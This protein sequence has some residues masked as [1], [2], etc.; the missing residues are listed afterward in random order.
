M[1]ATETKV[2]R[3]AAAKCQSMSEVDLY[4]FLGE[5]SAK[6]KTAKNERAER[7]LFQQVFAVED[8]L[9]AFYGRKSA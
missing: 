4:N 3:A 8:H 1:K 6:L 2:Y 5:L 9:K 7:T